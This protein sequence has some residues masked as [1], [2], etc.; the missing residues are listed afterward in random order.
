MTALAKGLD[1]FMAILFVPAMLFALSACRPPE[2]QKHEK[3]PPIPKLTVTTLDGGPLTM[4][5]DRVKG[6]QSQFVIRRFEDR[7]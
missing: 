4:Y 1:P 7:S 3:A 2:Q 6:G 5:D